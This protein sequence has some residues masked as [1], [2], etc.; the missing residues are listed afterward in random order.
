MRYKRKKHGRTRMVARLELLELAGPPGVEAYRRA[1]VG[2]DQWH[3]SCSSRTANTHPRQG[4]RG[5]LASGGAEDRRDEKSVH[6]AVKTRRK[7]GSRR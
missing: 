1:L 3:S 2:M 4:R 5:S 7:R 6:F